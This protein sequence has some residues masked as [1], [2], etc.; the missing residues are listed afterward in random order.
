M[1]TNFSLSN[2]TSSIPTC[3][4]PECAATAKSILDS[5]DLNVD[6]C[7]DFYQYT[8]KPF[9]FFSFTTYMN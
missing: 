6:P 5:L 1:S 2:S 4:T 7:S 3:S 8:C 9:F